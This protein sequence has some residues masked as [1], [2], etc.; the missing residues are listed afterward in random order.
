MT[1]YRH[2]ANRTAT[3][4]PQPQVPRKSIAFERGSLWVLELVNKKKAPDLFNPEIPASIGEISGDLVEDLT[5]AMNFNDSRL[6]IKRLASGRCFA[7]RVASKIATYCWVS[8]THECIG[9]LEH[10]IHMPPGEAYIWDC[11]TLPRFRGNHLYTAL[12]TAIIN[13]LYC[14]GYRRIWIGASLENR[15]SLRAFIRSG[16]HLAATMYYARAGN[17]GCL[18]ILKN[19]KA[20]SNVIPTIHHMLAAS[21]ERVVG[22]FLLTASRPISPPPCMETQS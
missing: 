8:T 14:E 4:P 6:V 9:E 19:H 1:A 20:F 2:S 10:E 12:L 5:R 16:F 3:S 17:F 11:A 21:Q 15:P 22:P 18:L 7:G 13:Q